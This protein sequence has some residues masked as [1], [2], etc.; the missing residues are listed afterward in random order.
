M[1]SFNF[2]VMSVSDHEKMNPKR[3]A[4]HVSLVTDEETEIQHGNMLIVTTVDAGEMF[5]VGHRYTV[6]IKEAQ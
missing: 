2:R 5:K 4:R 6:D 3:I 1:K